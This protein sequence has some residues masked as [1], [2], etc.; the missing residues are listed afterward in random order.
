MLFRSVYV[1]LASMLSG[2][3]C[4]GLIITFSRKSRA[5]FASRRAL[6]VAGAAMA[7]GTACYAFPAFDVFPFMIAGAVVSG[8]ASIW[9]V[10]FWGRLFSAL[11]AVPITRRR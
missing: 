2:V 7:A 8:I 1:H 4:Y 3:V 10:I 6:F 9:I 11:S 5:L